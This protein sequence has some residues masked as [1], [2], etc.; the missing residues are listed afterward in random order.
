VSEP[1]TQTGTIVDVELVTLG[2]EL[3]DSSNLTAGSTLITVVDASDYDAEDG[4][5][6]S[7]NGNLHTYVVNDP[8][9]GTL[10]ITPGLLATA[11]SGDRVDIWDI[12]VGAAA[13]EYRAFVELPGDIDNADAL[14]A[15]V[16]P[17]LIPL[18]SHNLGVRD[19]GTG[20]IAHLQLIGGE[21]VLI[22]MG[23]GIVQV[24][25]ETLV[26]GADVAGVFISGSDVTGSD[27]I[28]DTTVGGRVLLYALA[29]PT[30]QTITATGA[31]TF[32]VPAGITSLTVECWGPGGSG[33]GGASLGSFGAASGSGGEYAREDNLAVTPLGVYN[34]T[35][36]AGPAGAAAGVGTGATGSPTT[37]AG[38]SV[39]VVANPGGGAFGGFNIPGGDGSG[40]TVHF[41]GGA[42]AVGSDNGPAAGDGGGS[43]GGT[44]RRGKPG[45]QSPSN[46]QGGAGGGAVDG[47]GKG[48]AGGSQTAAGS[49]GATPGGGGGGGGG[50][51]GGH[52]G[53]AGGNGQIR[54]TYGGTSVLVGSLAALAGTDENGNAYP[55]GIRINRPDLIGVAG[56][57]VRNGT[58]SLS[59]PGTGANTQ[60]TSFTTRSIT[61]PGGGSSVNA[62]FMDSAFSGAWSSGTFT[63]PTG[64]AGTYS[65]TLF[66]GGATGAA[67]SRARIRVNGV[68]VAAGETTS[69]ASGP[70][71][72]ALTDY[73]LNDGDTVTFEVSQNSGGSLTMSGNMTLRRT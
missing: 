61:P 21:W 22:E 65:G 44:S 39:T 24:G 40:N 2:S 59:V 43:S 10:T 30:I 56:G 54:I 37:F 20:E 50:A 55:V 58:F 69:G 62:E 26:P 31:G 19:P 70:C 53:G 33:A 51:G 29:G 35:V 64:G 13:T 23:G 73:W 15:L 34:Y 14:D 45:N 49:A 68:Q 3:D 16:G 46:T 27:F 6:V 38:D 63:V 5:T 47:G 7:H 66:C 8:D 4:G 57:Y 72:A 41:P 18:L 42:N 17:S 1:T 32:T 71:D 67:M 9:A 48:G 60:I 12:S 11:S 25:T 28:M 52:A 36:G